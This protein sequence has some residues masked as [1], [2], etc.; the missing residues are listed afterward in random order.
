MKALNPVF[1]GKYYLNDGGLETTLIFHKNIPLNY[2]PPLAQVCSSSN[3][4]RPGTL[5]R[6]LLALASCA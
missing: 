3:D 1:K 5:R 6:R 4:R 2:F